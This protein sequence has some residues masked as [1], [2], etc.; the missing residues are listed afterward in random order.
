MLHISYPIPNMTW[1]TPVT[2]INCIDIRVYLV[3]HSA[4]GQT[5]GQTNLIPKQIINIIHKYSIILDRVKN[6]I[7]N[8]L[9]LL[10]KIIHE[11]GNKYNTEYLTR[12]KDTKYPKVIHLTFLI[13]SAYCRM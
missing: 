8:I 13:K 10:M 7:S 1:W 4:D 5:V 12:F 6:N 2:Y 3:P 9:P 11:R